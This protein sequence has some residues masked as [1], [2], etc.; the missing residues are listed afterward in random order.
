MNE[1]T[2]RKGRL[3][4]DLALIEDRAFGGEGDLVVEVEL[5]GAHADAGLGDRTHV[6]IPARPLVR[7]VPVRRPAKVGRV[8]VGRQP[9][10]EAMQLV[11]TAEVHLAAEDGAIASKP[12][13][14]GEGRDVGGEFRGI[15]VDAGPRGQAPGH[16]RRPRRRA[17]RACAIGVV[18]HDAV[19]RELRHVRAPGE[20]MAVDRQ[21]RR[22]HLIGH[23]DEDVWR[24]GGHRFVLVGLLAGLPVGLFAVFVCGL[25]S[26][27][28]GARVRAHSLSIT[29][30]SLGS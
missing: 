6:V 14:M 22:R 19:S 7:P 25:C 2:S 26:G 8:D 20:R 9:L 1:A 18:E 21:E 17:Q 15:V 4:F 29:G 3:S 23:D 11:G 5:V 12:Q 16:E 28:W 30:T 27:C 24:A 13:M 10:F